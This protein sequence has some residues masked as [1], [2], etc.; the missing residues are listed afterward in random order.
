MK[1]FE[2][3]L[4]VMEVLWE[5]G[6]LTAG[7]LSKELVHRTG[8]NRNTTYTIIKKLVKKGVLERIEPNFTCHPLISRSQVQQEEADSLVNRLFDGSAELLICTYLTEKKLNKEEI[9]RL[10]QLIETLN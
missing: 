2:S 7:Q 4:K 8:W 10:K 3:E 6:D 5:Q 9:I 1:L